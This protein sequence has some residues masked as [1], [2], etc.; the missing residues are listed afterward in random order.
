M[1]NLIVIIALLF[2]FLANGESYN[3]IPKN[4]RSNPVGMKSAQSLTE[5][6][7][8]SVIKRAKDIYVPIFKK[9]YK[10]E[11]VVEEKWDD[12]T[13]NAYAQQF[14]DK[15]QVTMFGGLARDPLLTEDGFMGVI[16]H[17]IGHH[18]G[19]APTVSSWASDEGQ[20]DYYAT[21]HCLKKV[22]AKDKSKNV[23]MLVR[24]NLTEDEQL[25]K[26]SCE[27]VYKN[28]DEQALC[29]RAS[30]AG[31][32]L[33]AVL[34]SLGEEGVTPKF[35]TPDPK[36]VTKTNHAHPA[37]QCRMD[38]YWAGA[39]CD[40]DLSVLMDKKDANVGSCTARN[41]HKLGL[42][43]LCWFNPKEYKVD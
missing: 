1:K 12:P 18:V 11:L 43:P 38:T 2:S 22:F 21:S 15:W 34:A 20:A 40:A 17:E 27:E 6:Q 19:G 13:E 31:Q 14:G 35:G 24:T 4:N 8:K 32:S 28:I 9:E 16:C 37:G 3:C 23:K 25:A 33:A 39:V 10:A 7:F 41:T 42:R 36:K 5:A 26:K 29:F 30:L